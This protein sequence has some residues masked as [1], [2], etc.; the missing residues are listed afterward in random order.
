MPHDD[1]DARDWDDA[2]PHRDPEEDDFAPV[3][4]TECGAEC[5]ALDD[6]LFGCTDDDCG[7]VQDEDGDYI[8]GGMSDAAERAWERQQMGFCDF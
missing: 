6:G 4:C 8:D 3:L 2:G 7:V 5:V 1:H